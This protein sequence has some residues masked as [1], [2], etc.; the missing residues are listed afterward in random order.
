MLGEL[1]SRVV[2][3]VPKS[4]FSTLRRQVLCGPMI[5]TILRPHDLKGKETGETGETTFAA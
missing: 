1:E 5:L 2:V 3:K 4:G